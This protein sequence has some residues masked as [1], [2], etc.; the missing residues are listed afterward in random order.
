MNTGIDVRQSLTIRQNCILYG[1]WLAYVALLWCVQYVVRSEH[2]SSLLTTA[3]YHAVGD[4]VDDVRPVSAAY[5]CSSDVD[6]D[7]AGNCETAADQHPTS[8]AL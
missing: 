7:A 3:P 6:E 5:P 8:L 2:D 4:E 1:G